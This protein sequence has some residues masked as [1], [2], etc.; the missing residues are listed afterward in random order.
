MA[1]R[2]YPK[3]KES[4]ENS[5]VEY[6]RLGNSGL[7]VSV[8]IFGCMSFGDPRTLDWAI[9][10]EEALPLLK[11]AYDR[12]LNTWDTANV[13]SNGASEIIVGKALKRYNI[14]REKVVI[15]TKCCF[16]VGEEPELR[17]FFVQK[18]LAESKD[19]VNQFGLSRA[20]IFNQV[21]ASL[22][23]LD[24]PYIDLLQIHR[25]DPN[26]PIEETMKALHDLVQSGKVRYIGASSMWATQFARMQFC[27]ERNGW[28]KFISMQNQYNLL[29]REEEREM[30]RFCNDTGV[31]LIPWAP[32]CRGHLARRPE[33]YG[34]TPRSKGEKENVPGAHGTV[35]PD[36]TIIKRVIEVADKH[37]W[38]MSHVALAWINKRVTSPIIGF[39]KLERLEEA[40]AA[41]GKVL[42]EEEE[43][44]LEE[45]YQPKP[46]NGH[47]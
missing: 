20:A 34:T 13:Y 25:F 31:G 14:P 44:Y 9:G 45:L 28:T 2:I 10:E 22:K 18:E 21:E 7:R 16:A 37:G 15:M 39:S 38:P 30:N 29:Y 32:L 41:R 26:T 35:E 40:I 5:K 42:T 3:L 46:I 19:Y 4:L 12:G 23:R 24:T 43:K 1:G 11:A 17:A 27:A 6:R 47:S 33:Q 8:P 36:L